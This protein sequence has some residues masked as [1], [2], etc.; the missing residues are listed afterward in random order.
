MGRPRPSIS[1]I[2]Q[3]NPGKVLFK[4]RHIK[5][6]DKFFIKYK[7]PIKRQNSSKKNRIDSVKPAI[8]I[9]SANSNPCL[10]N[11]GNLVFSYWFSI[12]KIDLK[13]METTHKNFP[14]HP[15]LN[16]SISICAIPNNNFF[17]IDFG[18]S[19]TFIIDKSLEISEA[20]RIE[21]RKY[22]SMIYLDGLIY[23][24]AIKPGLR[25]I[26]TYDLNR[27]RW[28]QAAS[29]KIRDPYY[30][31]ILAA[32]EGKIIIAPHGSSSVKAFDP[33]C[34]SASKILKLK[35]NYG[36]FLLA[37]NDKLYCIQSEGYAYESLPRDC[38][39]WMC[40][41]KTL[42]A[43]IYG[44]PM[45]SLYNDSIYFVGVPHCISL[46]EFNLKTRS[47]TFIDHLY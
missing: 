4:S 37:A 46:Y 2:K 14:Q 5:S 22:G 19:S 7:K 30:D 41:S 28:K 15:E 35:P 6:K 17:C 29:I 45:Y 43:R 10:Q 8:I 38:T 36:T 12:V 11:N 21:P 32:F 47:M 13:T 33:F 24:F 23:L 18:N 25:T 3:W 27:N 40:I 42:I 34:N 31:S 44:L 39:Q 20:K 9:K 16:K 1:K 26:E